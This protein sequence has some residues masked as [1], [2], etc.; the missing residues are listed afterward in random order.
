MTIPIPRTIYVTGVY[1]I[2]YFYML[3][4]IALILFFYYMFIIDPATQRREWKEFIARKA[5]YSV[6]YD[7]R[8]SKEILLN[9]L[10]NGIDFGD[11]DDET[12]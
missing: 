12:I 11:E 5:Y 8:R 3:P 6:S 2:E 9:V 4:F 1:M 10:K 7:E